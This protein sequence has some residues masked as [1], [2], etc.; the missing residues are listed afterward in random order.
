MESRPHL[1]RIAVLVLAC[2]L[3]A[4]AA[5]A[6]PGGAGFADSIQAYEEE[7]EWLGRAYDLPWS[8]QRSQRLDRFYREWQ[9]ALAA[10]DFA[11]LDQAGRVDWL[12]LHD[13]LEHRRALLV[14][15]HAR[16]A[17]IDALLPFRAGIDQLQ[18]RRWRLE[19]VDQPAAATTLGAIPAAL[20]A[21]RARLERGL[22][23]EAGGDGQPRRGT[24]KDDASPAKPDSSPAK[25]DAPAAKA[26]SPAA[27]PEQ[28]AP[29]RIAP[30]LAQ[31]AAHATDRIHQTMKA[32]YEA[33]DGSLPGFPFWMKQPYD[34]AAKALDDYAKFLREEVAGLKGGDDEPLLG[35]PIG[36]EG[37]AREL[38]AER[39]PYS[40]A[41]LLAIGERELAWCEARLKEAARAMGQ[42]DDWHAALAKVKEDYVPA[43][44]QDAF[45]AQQAADAIAFVTG[46]DLVTVPPLCQETWRL[47]MT[48]SEVQRQMPYVAYDGQRIL[49]AYAREDMRPADKLMAMRSNNRHFTRLTTAHELIPGHH[50]QAFF[51]ERFRP[52]RGAFWTPFLVEG[53]ALYWELALW[54]K[55]Y[56]QSPED[57]IGMLFWH[58]H[59]AARIIVTLRFHLGEMTPRQ[60]VDFLVERVGHEPASATS[61]VRRYIGGEASPLYQCGYLIGALQLRALE[62]EAT[63]GG[64][65]SEKAF[66]D[67]VLRCG[68]IPIELIRASLLM[69]PLTPQ[70]RPEWRFEK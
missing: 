24:G 50:L 49:A 30:L 36:A 6:K 3:A 8:E 37:L 32:W 19:P 61:E 12:L 41:E 48:S 33:Y 14:Q 68:P 20:R 23:P 42:G 63:A 10:T 13:H 62:V 43:G 58:M 66:N 4:T 26:D 7:H 55:G 46:H 35:E 60:M 53:W 15:E 69:V 17:E 16:L 47:T 45:I 21:L 38:A 18:A 9:E 28:A 44:A 2:C 56:A 29:L 31:R 54:D 11:A 59:R 64:R 27:K 52:Y 67:A 40:P 39:L 1:P 70:S 57:R 25:P 34:E 65:M 51:A 22:K 5:E